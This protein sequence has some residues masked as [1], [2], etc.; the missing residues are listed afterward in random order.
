MECLPNSSWVTCKHE[1]VIT[2]GHHVRA[3]KTWQSLQIK[4][5]VL[6]TVRQEFYLGAGHQTLL[7]R[8]RGSLQV[9]NVKK[10]AWDDCGAEHS[11]EQLSAQGTAVFNCFCRFGVKR[12]VTVDVVQPLATKQFLLNKPVSGLSHPLGLPYK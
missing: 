11:L 1:P 4:L 9:P 3:W 12:S 10:A 6:L 8:S 7:M 2:I 5:S